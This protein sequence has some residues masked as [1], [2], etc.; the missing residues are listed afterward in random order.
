MSEKIFQKVN[1]NK[2]IIKISNI[3]ILFIKKN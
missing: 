3:D 1:N 2:E